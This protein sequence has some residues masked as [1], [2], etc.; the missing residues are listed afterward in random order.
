MNQDNEIISFDYDTNHKSD[1]V[2][3]IIA[4]L[5]QSY[6]RYRDGI[7]DGTIKPPS[8]IF[9]APMWWWDTHCGI[10]DEVT[11]ESN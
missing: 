4:K 10:C 11:D 5:W 9:V 3:D 7:H 8:P 6:S 2:K 1:S